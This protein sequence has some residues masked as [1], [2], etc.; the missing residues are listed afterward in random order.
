MNEIQRLKAAVG[1]TGK[2]YDAANANYTAVVTRFNETNDCPC[3]DR[4]CYCICHDVFEL[5]S[6]LRTIVDKT[7]AAE[8]GS[9]AGAVAAVATPN[10]AVEMDSPPAS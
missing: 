8:G 9:G 5:H 10:E 3:A 4:V 2:Q 6:K 1:E 7:L